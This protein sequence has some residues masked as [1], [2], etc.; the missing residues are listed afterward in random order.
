V[1]AA[2]EA[3]DPDVREALDAA[4]ETLNSVL[5]ETRDVVVMHLG[6]PVAGEL[7]DRAVNWLKPLVARTAAV[8]N[9]T[10][11]ATTTELLNTQAAID[12]ILR[13]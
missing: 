13:L 4:S 12:A 11:T 3:A 1:I 9:G 7:A 2:Y 5:A 8:I 6:S 10:A